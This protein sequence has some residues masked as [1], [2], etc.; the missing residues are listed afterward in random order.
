MGQFDGPLPLESSFGC[1]LVEAGFFCLKI[2]MPG[3]PVSFSSQEL[4]FRITLLAETLS[5]LKA[6][7]HSKA[8]KEIAILESKR[9]HSPQKVFV[10][11]LEPKDPAQKP[12][13]DAGESPSDQ[14]K[15]GVTEAL[16]KSTTYQFGKDQPELT[17]LCC[18]EGGHAFLVGND[19]GEV[20]VLWH[21]Q[22]SLELIVRA[23]LQA[24]T[25]GILALSWAEGVLASSGTSGRIHLAD[26]PENQSTS[27][28]IK[29]SHAREMAPWVFFCYGMFICTQFSSHS[30]KHDMDQKFGHRQRVKDQ[31]RSGIGV[32]YFIESG[33]I[34][35]ETRNGKR[36]ECT[37]TIQGCIYVCI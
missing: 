21:G 23:S 24:Q 7:A 1:R 5:S 31:D 36:T 3:K 14:R 11:Q 29:S 32:R 13:K 10:W 26:L 15:D 37:D 34:L 18:Y 12:P 16:L 8:V 25:S 27:Q 9:D 17:T 28:S 6:F 35:V 30:K 22:S 19:H 33:I 2:C 20:F 4:T